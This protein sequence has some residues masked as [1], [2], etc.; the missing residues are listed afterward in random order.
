MQITGRDGSL[1]VILARKRAEREGVVGS[2]C[3]QN[4]ECELPTSRQVPK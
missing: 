3:D 1:D 2:L 4:L